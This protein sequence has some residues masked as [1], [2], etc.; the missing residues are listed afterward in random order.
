MGGSADDGSLVSGQSDGFGHI[1]ALLVR[2]KRTKDD[3]YTLVKDLLASRGVS[4]F[5]LIVCK[6]PYG[7]TWTHGNITRPTQ[8]DSSENPSERVQDATD[9][10]K[11]LRGVI[12][13]VW[14]LLNGPECERG[15]P[16]DLPQAVEA[17]LMSAAREYAKLRSELAGTTSENP[18]DQIRASIGAR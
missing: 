12:G 9:E 11:A 13:K 1:C 14:S 8:Q 6:A 3:L 4:F 2:T 7:A 16:E 10:V 17:R 5:S 18:L 15:R